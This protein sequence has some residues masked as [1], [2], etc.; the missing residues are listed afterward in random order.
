MVSMLSINQ[1]YTTLT[2]FFLSHRTNV[3]KGPVLGKTITTNAQTGNLV[4][5]IVAVISTLGRQLKV[6]YQSQSHTW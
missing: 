2:I 1:R 3:E 5:A 6:D 4:V